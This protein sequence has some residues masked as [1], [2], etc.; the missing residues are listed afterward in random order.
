MFSNIYD[1]LVIFT[2][3]LIRTIRKKIT[4]T[5]K[6]QKYARKI[7][8]K[9]IQQNVSKKSWKNPKISEKLAKIPKSQK[10]LKGF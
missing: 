5:L 1:H 7:A 6:T 9:R 4:K 3:D 2:K 10:K 8:P